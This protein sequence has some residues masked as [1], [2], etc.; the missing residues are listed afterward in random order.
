VCPGAVDDRWYELRLLRFASVYVMALWLKSD[1]PDEPD[2]IYPLEP[3]PP[4]LEGH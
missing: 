1:A 2:I 3:A 4:P